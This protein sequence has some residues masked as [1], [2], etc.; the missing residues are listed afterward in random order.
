VA[1]VLTD[2]MPTAKDDALDVV[3]EAKIAAQALSASGVEVYAIG[4]G[5]GVNLDFVKQIASREELAYY[6]PTTADL[7]GIYA[8]ITNSLCESGT[9]K[10][11]VIAK[12]RTNF[13]PL[14]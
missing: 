14:R 6:A 11:E 9:T 13:A 12:T 1:V 10:I 3:G 2:G 5:K 4:L 8:T 7:S